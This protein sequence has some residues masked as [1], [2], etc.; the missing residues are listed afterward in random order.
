MLSRMRLDLYRILLLVLLMV[1]LVAGLLYWRLRVYEGQ[2]A[3][4]PTL[5]E[6]VQL[7]D[8][9]FE[10]LTLQ[11]N[12]PIDKVVSA[13]GTVATY[14]IEGRFVEG[15]E[16]WQDLYVGQLVV[17]GDVAERRIPVYVGAMDG[18]VSW[19]VVKEQVR[20]AATWQTRATAE[21]L[22]EL[23][24]ADRVVVRTEL[25]LQGQVAESELGKSM[26]RAQ[27]ILDELLLEIRA[28]EAELTLP[29]EFKLLS[30][31]V[32]VIEE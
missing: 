15:W 31:M 16:Q 32:G 25:S 21:V 23:L 2:Q 29:P 26:L 20:G 7:S 28:G 9:P 1:A 18:M 11:A 3:T 12:D 6:S 14:N 5:Q 19:G 24:R 17:R 10:L 13:D 30:Y 22:D 8:G 4:T 27:A